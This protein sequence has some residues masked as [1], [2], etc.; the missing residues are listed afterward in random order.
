MG[1]KEDIEKKAEREEK[2]QMIEG[3][4]GAI[5]VKANQTKN[6]E[7]LDELLLNLRKISGLQSPVP[8]D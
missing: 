4:L 5:R 6:L 2:I 3:N 8:V 7:R 1:I